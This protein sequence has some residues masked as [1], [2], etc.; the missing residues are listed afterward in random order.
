MN[1]LINEGMSNIH[2][3]TTIEKNWLSQSFGFL[4][5][6]NSSPGQLLGSFNSRRYHWILK[7]FIVT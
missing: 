6:R 3:K 2:L 4:S 5:L 7:F 1:G